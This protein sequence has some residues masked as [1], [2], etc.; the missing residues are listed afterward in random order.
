MLAPIYLR[1]GRA[2][3]AV[4]A[5]RNT[6][7]I[8][9]A[10]ADRESGLGEAIAMAAGGMI[11]ADARGGLRAR[12]GL[13]EP[14]NAKAQFYLASALAQEGKLAEAAA[15]WQAMLGTLPADSP[16]RSPIERG[17]RRGR[18]PRSVAAGRRPAQTA[19]A[20]TRSTRP[21]KCRRRIAPR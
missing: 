7:S 16:W 13:A 10:T 17:D 20:R 19:Q 6:I 2:G 5:Y 11:S 12:A 21:P 15:A 1:I 8:N 14:G 4:I 18:A 3:D 9:G